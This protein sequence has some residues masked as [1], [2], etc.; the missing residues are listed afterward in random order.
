MTT[1]RWLEA[2]EG[3]ELHQGLEFLNKVSVIKCSQNKQVFQTQT[4]KIK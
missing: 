4:S 3:L 2:L 1:T